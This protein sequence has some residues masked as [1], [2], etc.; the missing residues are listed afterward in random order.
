MESL[1]VCEKCFLPCQSGTPCA[2]RKKHCGHEL[3]KTC[4]ATSFGKSYHDPNLQEQPSACCAMSKTRKM[5]SLLSRVSTPPTSQDINLREGG[6][7]NQEKRIRAV[8]LLEPCANSCLQMILRQKRLIFLYPQTTYLK[9]LLCH[10][11]NARFTIK[12]C[13]TFA[14]V[15]V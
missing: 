6:T 10:P 8:A 7:R 3:C 13:S 1:T 12:L 11:R 15:S 14:L 2:L 5:L 4:D 9:L